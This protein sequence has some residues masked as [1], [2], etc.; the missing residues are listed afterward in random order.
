M[1]CHKESR[2]Y[3]TSYLDLNSVVERLPGIL[4][5]AGSC[6]TNASVRE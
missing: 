6:V 4:I 1:H 2:G 3:P 5:K